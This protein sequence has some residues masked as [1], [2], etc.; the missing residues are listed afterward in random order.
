MRRLIYGTLSIYGL[1]TDNTV[2]TTIIARMANS[3]LNRSTCMIASFFHFLPEKMTKGQLDTIKFV[4]L[5]QKFSGLFTTG[6]RLYIISM[7]VTAISDGLRN[8][9][10]KGKLYSYR[11]EYK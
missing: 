5:E 2:I 6:T 3:L 1:M 9:R 4:H 7:C 10:R 8:T 11:G